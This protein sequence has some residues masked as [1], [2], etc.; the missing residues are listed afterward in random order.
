MENY[1]FV[2]LKTWQ[3]YF[4]QRF[5]GLSFVH[6]LE[7]QP[8]ELL[9][10]LII[11]MHVLCARTLLGMSEKWRLLLALLWGVR[12]ADDGLQVRPGEGSRGLQL[13]PH[14]VCQKNG[15]RDERS[16]RLPSGEN[17]GWSPSGWE[18][19]WPAMRSAGLGCERRCRP[20]PALTFS[21]TG[22]GE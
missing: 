21:D 17:P 3:V 15:P 6:F 19:V 13:L 11:I 22:P 12:G 14:T 8:D 1:S 2:T 4:K 7:P 10:S 16:Q 9:F 5:W 20:V 18:A